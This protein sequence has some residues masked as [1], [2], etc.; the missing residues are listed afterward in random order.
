MLTIYQLLLL[1]LD[2]DLV[3]VSAK[4][5]SLFAGANTNLDRRYCYDY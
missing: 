2:L 3:E 5:Y 1:A 4:K